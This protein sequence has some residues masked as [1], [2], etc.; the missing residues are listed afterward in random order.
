METRAHH[1]LIGA[2]TLLVL[3]AGALSVLWLGRTRFSPRWDPYDVVFEESVTG[4][5]VGGAVQYNGI[6]VGEVRKLSLDPD[7]PRR[8]IARIRVSG[9]TPVKTDTRAKLNFTGLTFVAIIQFSHGTPSAPLLR[10]RDGEEVP[11][12]F[13]DKSS[14]Q[15]LLTSGEDM[16]TVAGDVLLR[17]S[18]ALDEKNLDKVSATLDHIEKVTGTL[19]DHD[20]DI[21]AALVDLRLAS[22]GLKRTLARTEKTMDSVDKLARSSDRLLNEDGKT[23]LLSAARLADAAQALILQNQKALAS[24]SNKDLAQVGPTLAELSSTARALRTLA[25]QLDKDPQS[26]LQGKKEKPRERA[27]K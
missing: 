4:L 13:A 20:D 2:F 22:L 23:L 18:K 1:V 16:L 27:A 15:T 26:L 10:P 24:F 21:G 8:V 17:L 7:D 6:Q 5:T 19:A 12:I 14:V 9:G 3:L 11:R 25:E